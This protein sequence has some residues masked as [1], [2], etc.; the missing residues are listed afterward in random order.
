MF[1]R[2]N[3]PPA[4]RGLVS[5]TSRAHPPPLNWIYVDRFTHEVRYGS[6]AVADGHILGPWDW[7]DDEVG[8]T[9]EGWEGFVAVEE[10]KGIWAVYYDR[11]DDSLKG[12]VPKGTRVLQ[13]SLERRVIEFDE[14]E[15]VE[16][17]QR[18]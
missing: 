12:R 6:R 17:V 9:L 5:T 11:D 15:V 13:C 14:G 7:T 8:L 1:E 10:E 18:R 4:F 3:R 16:P 2:L